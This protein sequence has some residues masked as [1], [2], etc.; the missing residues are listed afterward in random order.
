M[1]L[2]LMPSS[3][4]NWDYRGGAITRKNKYL[5]IQITINFTMEE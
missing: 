2:Q 1:W 3:E 5:K 4:N